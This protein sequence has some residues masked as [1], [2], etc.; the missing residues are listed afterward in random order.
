MSFEFATAGRIVFGWGAFDQVPAL[1]STLGRTALLVLGREGRHGAALAGKLAEQ[2]IRSFAFHVDGEPKVRTVET[3]VHLARAE[4]CDLVIAV[5]G[6]SVIDA[7]KATAGMATQAGGLLDHL[8]IVGGGRPLTAPGLPFVAVPTTAGT[9]SEVTRNA[10]LDVPERR[11]KV[12]L[13]SPA[14]LPR[15]AVVD[16]G[17]TLSLPS[18][19]TATTGMDALTQLIEPFVGLGANPLTD[20]ICRE[21]IA[22]AARS[23]A[24]A[25]RDGADRQAREDMAT[26]SLFGGLALA[27]A[28]L[29]A[30]HGLA[31]VLGGTFSVPHGAI[32]ARLLPLVM[33]ANI[34]AIERHSPD[35]PALNRYRE[36]AQILT[37]DFAAE[38]HDGVEWVRALGVELKIP[39][40]P[41]AEATAEELDSVLAVARG[42]SSMKGNPIVLTDAQLREILDAA[43]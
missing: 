14:L 7:G 2:G 34:A 20:G 33:N 38:A 21:G 19:I 3:A 35:S 30:V 8:E 26:A 6:G 41:F 43:G 11:V 32:C 29:G 23:L 40:L 39:P 10:V 5:G 22:L 1:A 9:G 12:S 13:R 24:T 15:A 27:N 36:V 37:G 17:L 42:A 28:K 16:P 18:E 4:G 25:H 31:G